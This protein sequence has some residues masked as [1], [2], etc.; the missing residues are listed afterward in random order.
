M[1]SHQTCWSHTKKRNVDI[2]SHPLIDKQGSCM[3]LSHQQTP[4]VPYGSLTAWED[5]SKR[6][7]KKNI[8]WRTSEVLP[9]MVVSRD[10]GELKWLC[11]ARYAANLLCLPNPS[12]WTRL[13]DQSCSLWI[14][15]IKAPTLVP[16]L[17]AAV[18]P[19]EMI[20]LQQPQWHLRSGF[21]PSPAALGRSRASWS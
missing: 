18:L 13:H 20:R 8:R 4:Q 19:L 7:R 9:V 15:C 5:T 1:L 6:L 11:D 12:S 2:N 3:S 17:E 14:I 16:C 21:C 10:L